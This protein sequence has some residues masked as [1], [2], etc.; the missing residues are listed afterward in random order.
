MYI[1]PLPYQVRTVAARSVGDFSLG[2]AV[3]GQGPTRVSVFPFSIFVVFD[4]LNN[5]TQ[6]YMQV[7]YKQ[8]TVKTKPLCT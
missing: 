3:L 7:P 4:M 2:L 5:G 8:E 6:Q 1:Q